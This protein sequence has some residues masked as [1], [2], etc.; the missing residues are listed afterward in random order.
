MSF[1]VSSSFFSQ[2][3]HSCI[4]H[5]CYCCF[6]IYFHFIWK[7]KIPKQKSTK[8]MRES[9]D[10][11]TAKWIIS[12]IRKLEI[13]CWKYKLAVEFDIIAW[14]R[15]CA[16]VCVCV[17]VYEWLCSLWLPCKVP[18]SKWFIKYFSIET[19]RCIQ[20]SGIIIVSFHYNHGDRSKSFAQWISF[21]LPL[22]RR[23]KSIQKVTGY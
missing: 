19:L 8:T 9:D 17:C 2:I 14:L 20:I 11:T 21:S 12:V 15:L 1:F 5:Y 3:F 22:S 18:Q 10:G 4:L 13:A 16:R 23:K 6:V 7:I